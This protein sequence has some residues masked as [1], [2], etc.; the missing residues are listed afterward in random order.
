[1]QHSFNVGVAKKYDVTTAI[2]LDNL[3]FWTEKNRA[4]EKHFYE[5]RFWTYNSKKA[6]V[7]LFPYLTARQIDYAVKKMVESGIIITGN[8]NEN[9]YDRTLWY[10][11]TD[12]GYSILQNCEM[13][14]YNSTYNK[15]K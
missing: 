7:E 10:A 12:F 9:K 8:F 4:N 5:G 6:M 2:I 13:D 14:I 3:F 1:M 15:P 11:I